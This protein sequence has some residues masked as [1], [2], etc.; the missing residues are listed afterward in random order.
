MLKLHIAPIDTIKQII[1]WK[2]PFSYSCTKIIIISCYIQ[3]CALKP[4]V[5]QIIIVIFFISMFQPSFHE[6]CAVILQLFSDST[7]SNNN[8]IS[9]KE[10]Y[11]EASEYIFQ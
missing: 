3:K 9:S 8:I 10:G 11:G 2:I 1:Y 5:I 7:A 4:H 6:M